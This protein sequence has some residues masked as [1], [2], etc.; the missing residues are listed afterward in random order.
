MALLRRGSD[1]SDGTVL[2]SQDPS[3]SIIAAVQSSEWSSTPLQVVEIK[4]GVPYIYMYL[5]SLAQDY[6]LG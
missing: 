6:L 5:M 4:S 3:R 1:Q 2:L